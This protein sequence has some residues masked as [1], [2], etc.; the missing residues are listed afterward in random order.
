MPS[1]PSSAPRRRIES[2][3]R[4]SRSTIASAASA[5]RDRVSGARECVGGCV[6]NVAIEVLVYSVNTARQGRANVLG[7]GSSGLPIPLGIPH[8]LRGLD[9]PLRGRERL[10]RRSE[11]RRDHPDLGG[12]TPPPAHRERAAALQPHRV[13]PPLRQADPPPPP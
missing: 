10:R 4:P 6:D 7:L 11:E 1:T 3:S 13:H 9:G 5:M 12:G 2:A 8:R